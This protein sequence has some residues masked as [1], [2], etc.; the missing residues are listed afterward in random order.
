MMLDQSVI[1]FRCS[2][3]DFIIFDYNRWGQ[4]W[5]A[6]RGWQR[7]TLLFRLLIPV[8]FDRLSCK[9]VRVLSRW[10]DGYGP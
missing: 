1:N 7:Q 5:E 6:S 9:D 3:V 4:V 8:G 10:R 2:L